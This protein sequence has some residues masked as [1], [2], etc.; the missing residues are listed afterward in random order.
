MERQRRYPSDLT[1]EHAAAAEMD[2]A[3]GGSP[4]RSI[5]DAVLYVAPPAA[6][7][8]N[9][10]PTCRRGK[11]STGTSRNG[12]NVASLLDELREQ[13]RLDHGR[14]P[15]PTT[16]IIDSQSVKGADTVGRVSR[17]YD[18]GKRSTVGTGSW[19]PTPS[20]CSSWS[21]WSR[22]ACTTSTAPSPRCSACTWHADPVRVGRGRLRRQAHR[23][24]RPGPQDHPAR[25]VAAGLES[26]LV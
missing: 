6:R 17:G 13:V 9:C 22:P 15:E 21:V 11:R 4:R 2:R 5:V 3:V 23:L 8:G 16:G 18:A 24:G 19:S 25:R 12:T 1:D 20:A 10:R 26:D 7:G 14:E